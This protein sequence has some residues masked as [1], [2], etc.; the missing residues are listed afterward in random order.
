MRKRPLFIILI[1]TVLLVSIPG[2]MISIQDMNFSYPAAAVMIQTIKNGQLSRLIPITGNPSDPDAAVEAALEQAEAMRG[3][4][5]PAVSADAAAPA[6]GGTEAPTETEESTEEGEEHS[7][8]EDSDDEDHDD[9]DDEDHDHEDDEEDEEHED[10]NDED[11]DGLKEFTTVDD[12]YFEDACFI[13]DSRVQGLGLYS[14]LPATNYGVVGL[15]LSRVFDK[16]IDTEIGKATI[17]EALAMGRQ[18]GKIYLKFGLN[19]LGWGTD[20]QFAN[21]YYGLID[22]IKAVQPD[23]IIYVMGLLHVTEGEEQKSS[24]FT[25]EHINHRNEVIKEVTENEHVYY[26]DVNEVFTDE[27]GRMPSEDSFD[28]IH[29]KADA[30]GKWVDYLK[31]HAIE[32]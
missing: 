28:G 17:P 19:E 18:Y 4:P 32:D 21:Y 27:Y 25:N 26:L 12:D 9:E 14:D 22:Y 16:K 10:E 15:S 20:E 23:A 13:G 3:V 8:D 30:I 11:G 6:E 24:V 1:I 7:E 2:A 31:T 5:I 29:V